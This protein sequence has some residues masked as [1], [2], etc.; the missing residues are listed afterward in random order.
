[1]PLHTADALILRTY[2]LGEADRIVVF[3]TGDRGKRRGVA[4]DARRLRS[5]FTG[6]L[7]PLT[8]ARVAYFEREHRDLVRLSYVEPV[9]S[10]LVSRS[11]DA[12]SH[13]GY[14]A[15]LIDEW[16]PEAD[17]N[18]KLFR[19][20]A[21]V[22]EALAADVPVD[23]LARYFEYWLL[24]LQGVYPSIVA[25]HQCGA[26]LGDGGARIASRHWVFVC[27]GCGPADGGVDLSA[28][29]LAFLRAANTVAPDRLTTVS[30]SAGVDRELATAHGRLIEAHLE[31]ELKSVRVIRELSGPVRNYG[32]APR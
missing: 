23:R 17:P 9:C 1:M 16:A 28:E 5:R 2:K 20:G 11:A 29:A 24:R 6:G 15:E 4:K 3:L 25:C 22:T 14:F 19:L 13:V 27:E 10:P 12:L 26:D 30:L 7:E 32:E 31:K 21:S 18:D 8:R